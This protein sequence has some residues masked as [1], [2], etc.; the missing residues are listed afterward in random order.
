MSETAKPPAPKGKLFSGKNKWYLIGGL[1]GAVVIYFYVK[2]NNAASTATSTTAD[3]TSTDSSDYDTGSYYDDSDYGDYSA[4]SGVSP[5]L[6][7]YYDPSTGAYITGTGTTTV[8]SP[9]TNAQWV[10]QAAAYLEQSGYDPTTVLAALGLY[11][12]G[13]N[14][15]NDQLQIVQAAL[16]AEGYP[17]SPPSLPPHTAPPAGQTSGTSTKSTAL[18]APSL[19][20]SAKK[21][22]GKSA[23]QTL[24]WNKP[25]NT[26]EFH[27]YRNGKL[28]MLFPGTQTSHAVNHNG[29][30]QIVAAPV[31]AGTNAGKYH[32]SPMSNGVTTSGLPN[33]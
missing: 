24:S 21:G 30:W 14:L 25:A 9:S 10:Q 31:T 33:N 15:T 20:V 26:Y 32:S 3:T 2:R 4:A 1:G 12:T 16:A 11:L 17:P 5:S 7:G 22:S 19:K 18:A 6:Y 8:T 23:S 29:Y 28:W 13:S 27:L